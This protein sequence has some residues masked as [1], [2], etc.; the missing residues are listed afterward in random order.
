MIDHKI[1]HLSCVF[2]YWR[3]LA[4]FTSTKKWNKKGKY[5]DRVQI[6]TFFLSI[7][8][9]DVKD[10]KTI[11]TDGNLFRK[12]VLKRIDVVVFMVRGI[13]LGNGFW[14]VNTWRA[15]VQKQLQESIVN[16]AHT[17]LTDCC[18][19]IS[20]LSVI[21]MHSSWSVYSCMSNIMSSI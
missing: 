13:S 4:Y 15:P 18:T 17:F 20:D 1:F 16:F 19:Q 2:F 11:L 3:F 14:V 12:Q 10:F 7:V 21:I 9:F 5:P 8:L 6:F